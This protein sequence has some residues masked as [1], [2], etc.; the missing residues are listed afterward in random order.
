M[1]LLN[2]TI[3]KCGGI[4]RIIATVAEELAEYHQVFGNTE[5]WLKYIHG[6][7]MGKL[8]TGTKFLSLTGLFSWMQ[9]YFDA[10]PDSLKPCIFYLSVFPAG[11]NIKRRRLLRRWIAECYSRDTSSSTAAENGNKLF[12]ELVK[13][14]IIQHKAGKTHCQVNGF[15][16]GYIISRPMEDNLV[17]AL[18]GN[19][20]LSSQRAGQH[21]AI[22]SSW[23]RRDITV[24]TSMD[25]SR[26]RPLTVIG[27][28]RSFFISTAMGLLRVL[29]L[30]DTTNATNDDLEL[31]GKVMPRLKF[32]SVRGC[33]EIS[34]LPESLGELSQLQTLD[35]RHTSVVMLPPVIAKLKKLQYVRAGTTVSSDEYDG[36]GMACVPLSDE[37]QTSTPLE[38]RDESAAILPAQKFDVQTVDVHAM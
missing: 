34:Q 23:D 30:A 20:R 6:D 19:C 22:R 27:E 33:K 7:F 12:S 38:D 1:E 26:L 28:W 25:L 15:F 37:E 32:L 5:Y 9:S 35:V 29:D 10:C 14:S 13:L 18:E 11:Y 17:Y 8:E 16:H 31:I 24:F 3:A 36:N 4:P 21:L 2:L